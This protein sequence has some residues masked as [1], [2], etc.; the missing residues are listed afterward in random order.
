MVQFTIRLFGIIAVFLLVA[1]PGPVFAE[2]RW[3]VTDN[4]IKIGDTEN[5]SGDFVTWSGTKDADG[6]ADGTGTLQFFVSGNPGNR[7]EGMMAHGKLQGQGVLTWANGDR[8]E[9]DFADNKR[10]GKGV[11]LWTNGDRY[12]GSFVD[13]KAQG[14]GV[15]SWANG[16]RYEGDFAGDKQTGKGLFS[17]TSGD[18]Y[19]GDFVDNKQNGK[20]VLS[21]ANGTRYEG[22]FVNDRMD[23]YGTLYRQNGTI[24]R[25]YWSNGKYIGK[26]PGPSE[27]NASAQQYIE[28]KIVNKIYIKGNTI[29]AEKNILAALPALQEG[30]T[31]DTQALSREILLA[32]ENSFRHLAVNFRANGDKLDA[33]VNVKEVVASKAIVSVDNSGNAYTGWLR[34]RFTYL[35]G[36]FGG[37]GQTAVLSYTTSPDHAADV[38]QFGFFYNIPLPRAKDNFYLT[39]SYSDTNSGRIISQDFL[40]ID[41]TGKGSSVGLHYVHNLTRKPLEKSEID[42]GLDA[43]QY[44]N[45]TILTFAGTPINIGVDIDSMPF[46][47]SYQ[48]NKRVGS[49]VMSYSLS[50][51]HNIPGS[52]KNSTAQ[53]ERY[54]FG[55]S[56][57]YELWRGSF[58]YQHLYPSGWLTNIA[59]SGQYTNER[60]IY[61]EQ[62]GLGGTGSLRGMNERDVAGD[63]G[64]QGRFELYTPEF[65]KG[66]RALLFIDAGYFDNIRPIAGDLTGDS[67][68][69]CG[70]GWRFSSIN[71]F[72]AV[73]DYGYMLNGTANT[74]AHSSKFHFAVSK[75]L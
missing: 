44:Q 37:T 74:P 18:R 57:N 33:Y 42:V 24:V 7:Y 67:A 21:W 75:I 16:D 64:V 17:W 31:V 48:G 69:S 51:I 43:R 50:Y 25:G 72:S 35:D 71:G 19:E 66:Q 3:T 13:G 8:Y 40:S 65:T 22:S 59:L 15:F 61:P 54:R 49:N 1:L 11:L 36:N 41:A 9:G 47:V 46:S 34:S 60:L 58:D 68:V 30:R 70:L 27:Q 56:A 6:F 20:G 53:Y 55:T 28:N 4:G 39:A 38:K 26:A 10:S 5:V 14:K 2:E 73:A 62:F 23:G 29:S 32:N 45:G 12:E 52:E 63:R